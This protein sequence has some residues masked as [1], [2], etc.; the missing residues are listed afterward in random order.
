[1]ARRHTR[2]LLRP[3]GALAVNPHHRVQAVG[4][5]AGEA[6]A[7]LLMASGVTDYDRLGPA[8][9]AAYDHASDARREPTS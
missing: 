4:E 9:R 5:I 1:M 7:R 8:M 3:P 2:P 6:F